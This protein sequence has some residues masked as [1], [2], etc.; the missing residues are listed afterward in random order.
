MRW[1][2]RMFV[3]RFAARLVRELM[4]R[5]TESAAQG[6]ARTSSRPAPFGNLPYGGE[7]RRSQS[8]R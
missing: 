4:N 3:A 2:I 5:F 7:S 1:L 6:K 8:V